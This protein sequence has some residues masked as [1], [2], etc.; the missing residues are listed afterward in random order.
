MGKSYGDNAKCPSALPCVLLHAS[1]SS[2]LLQFEQSFLD[3]WAEEHLAISPD[4][5]FW[6]WGIWLCSHHV[7]GAW[8][9]L[10]DER[11]DKPTGCQVVSHCLH[12]L[13]SWKL[14]I[15]TADCEL[16]AFFK[17]VKKISEVT[18]V[19]TFLGHEFLVC[20]AGERWGKGH[21][22]GEIKPVKLFQELLIL[23]KMQ[24]LG[25]FTK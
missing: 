14:L 17:S 20:L 23:I 21:T 24:H 13:G 16:L 1:V 25:T 7:D 11:R 4:C 12:C 8:K 15:R 19:V 9:W 18:K 2:S 5:S 22:M 10:D 6:G 3:N